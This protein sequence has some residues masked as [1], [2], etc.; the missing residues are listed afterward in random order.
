MKPAVLE[1]LPWR[2]AGLVLLGV[3]VVLYQSDQGDLLNRLVIPVAI[4]LSAWLLVQKVLAVALGAGLL[5]AIHSDPQGDWIAALAYPLL[6]LA[7]GAVVLY[8][9]VQRF[10]R[11]I[12]ETHEARW[13][14]RRDDGDGTRGG[15]DT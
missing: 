9:L 12:A 10:R 13:R 6:A 14:H 7:C 3:L 4:A 15:D 1:N 2:V 5:A 8:V 11:R